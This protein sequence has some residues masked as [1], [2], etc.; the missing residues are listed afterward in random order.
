MSADQCPIHFKGRVWGEDGILGPHE[1]L[2]CPWCRGFA[3]GKAAGAEEERSACLA[4]IDEQ[5]IAAANVRK[6][7][8]DRGTR[9]MIC[10][11]RMYLGYAAGA[12]RARGKTGERS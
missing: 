6:P 7:V 3:A 11:R 5:M 8:R 1:P 9:L 10:D 2:H 12:I 4:I